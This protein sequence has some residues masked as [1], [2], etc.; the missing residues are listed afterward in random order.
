MTRMSQEL[1]EALNEGHNLSQSS[2][3]NSQ[4][5]EGVYCTPEYLSL[6]FC[7]PVD[8]AVTTWSQEAGKV[9][10]CILLMGIINA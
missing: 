8:Q 6:D 5:A 2:V 3:R 10:F 4:S 9:V 7:T 1:G